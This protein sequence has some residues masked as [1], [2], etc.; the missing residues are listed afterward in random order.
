[1]ESKVDMDDVKLYSAN[2]VGF[3]TMEEFSRDIRMTFGPDICR[4]N[5][6]KYAKWQRTDY[7]MLVNLEEEK[8]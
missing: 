1:M 3:R 7:S 2:A 5:A 8:Y 6:F 4:E